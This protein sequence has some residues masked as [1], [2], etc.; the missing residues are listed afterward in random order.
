VPVVDLTGGPP[1]SCAIDLVRLVSSPLCTFVLLC[2][3]LHSPPGSCAWF[4]DWPFRLLFP[5]TPLLL[6][7]WP[8]SPEAALPPVDSE[9][10][11]PVGVVD[12]APSPNEDAEV[13]PAAALPPVP[14]VPLAP[15][16]VVEAPPLPTVEADMP[17]PP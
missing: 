11:D 6:M 8:P 15:F 9:E 17:P 1:G 2:D 3:L 4:I 5:C 10:E 13:L 7:T 12:W 14:T 16:G